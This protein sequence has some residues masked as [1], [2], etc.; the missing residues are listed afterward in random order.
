MFDLSGTDI[1]PSNTDALELYLQ[2]FAEYAN[3]CKQCVAKSLD[4]KFNNHPS[5][6]LKFSQYLPAHDTIIDKIKETAASESGDQLENK[7]AIKNWFFQN[8]KQVI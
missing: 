8:F 3:K 4:L 1:E 7:E 6:L 2:N 5:S